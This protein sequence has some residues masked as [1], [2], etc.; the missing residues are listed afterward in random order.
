M[1]KAGQTP[2]QNNHNHHKPCCSLC[3]LSFVQCSHSNDGQR[4][5]HERCSATSREVDGP[6][7]AAVTVGYVAAAVPQGSSSCLQGGDGIDGRAVCWW[8]T[9]VACGFATAGWMLMPTPGR[10]V[11][12]A[13]LGGAPP[14]P[15]EREEEEEKAPESLLTLVFHLQPVLCALGIL[16]IMSDG[17][18]SCSS[19]SGSGRCLRS[20]VGTRAC[21][22]LCGLWT[23]PVGP[24]SRGGFSRGPWT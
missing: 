2:S 13:S 6:Q 18:G 12:M 1:G 3:Y 16:D 10:V 21:V 23:F 19:L 7:G 8:S 9:S 20:T 4:A 24:H 14:D 17:L 5:A 15:D 11:R 22:S